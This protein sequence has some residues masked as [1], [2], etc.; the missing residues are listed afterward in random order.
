M[1]PP[2]RLRTRRPAWEGHLFEAGAQCPL[3]LRQRREIQALLWLRSRAGQSAISRNSA[4]RSA[5]PLRPRCALAAVRPGAGGITLSG[6]RHRSRPQP[7]RCSSRSRRSADAGRPICP[8]NRIVSP[9]GRTTARRRGRLPRSRRRLRP[10]ESARP[11]HRNVQPR[12]RTANPDLSIST[13]AWLSFTRCTAAWRRP[14]TASI[15]QPTSSRKRQP[16]ASTARTPGCCA[17]TCKQP[18]NGPAKPS[19]SSLPATPRT[20]P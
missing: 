1:R 8:G 16:R 9:R 12:G 20:A 2:R 5:K 7:F 13:C 11:G 6:C 17:A 3:P 15:A 10:P 19:P 4:I 14:A 18:K